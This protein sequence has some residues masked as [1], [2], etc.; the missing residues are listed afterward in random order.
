MFY[1]EYEHNIDKKGRL[2]IPAKFREVYKEKFKKHLL[3]MW[4]IILRMI[5]VNKKLKVIS[6]SLLKIQKKEKGYF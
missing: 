3:N 5:P 6:E 2:I 1:G 4:M